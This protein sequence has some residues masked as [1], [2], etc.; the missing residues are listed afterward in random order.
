M[1]I[2]LHAYQEKKLKKD[3]GLQ[4][5]SIFNY[6]IARN[7]L[8]NEIYIFNRKITELSFPCHGR[9]FR[10]KIND[11]QYVRAGHLKRQLGEDTTN[12]LQQHN[13]FN[14]NVRNL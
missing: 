10:A 12:I 3:S 9:L 5:F 7:N 14:D 11:T 2:L 8:R 6:C 13:E 4:S 1:K